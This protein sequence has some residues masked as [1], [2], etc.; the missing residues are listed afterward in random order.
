MIDEPKLL[1][2]ADWQTRLR[3]DNDSEYQIYVANAEALGWPIKSYEEW[4][5]S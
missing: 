1:P 3:G 5:N 2:Q 4:L